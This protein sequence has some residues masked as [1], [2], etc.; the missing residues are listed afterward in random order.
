MTTESDVSVQS[1]REAG[2][3]PGRREHSWRDP[4]VVVAVFALLVSFFTGVYAY[5]Q[6]KVAREQA[7]A[8]EQQQLVSLV[9]SIAQ[10]NEASGSVT[11]PLSVSI[12]NRSEELVDGQAAAILINDLPPADVSTTEYVQVGKALADGGDF[13]TAISY[14]G[15]VR[16]SPQDPDSF[17][18]AM[19]NDAIVWY[20]IADNKFLL[21]RPRLA[22]ENTAERDMVRAAGAY[23]SRRSLVELSDEVESIAFT[24]LVDASWQVLI[25]GHCQTA[26]GDVIHALRTL[27]RDPAEGRNTQIAPLLAA[28]LAS[29]KKACP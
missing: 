4:P 19:R 7:T 17:A 10:L 2:G 13:R 15:K 16:F 5:S 8:S 14:F 21:P 18:N 26:E 28:D 11:S 22:D 20:E 3:K 27:L 1:D 9:I 25:T 23:T 6:V 29:V 12:G 24:Y